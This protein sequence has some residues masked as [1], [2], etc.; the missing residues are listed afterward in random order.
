MR[1]SSSVTIVELRQYTLV[2][3]R[4]D[5]LIDLFDREFITPQEDV[6]A[7]II[8]QFRD[9]E[10]PERFVWLR[11]FKDMRSRAAALSAF[12]G[13][14]VWKAHRDAANATMVD[15]DNVLLLRPARPNSGFALAERGAKTDSPRV[16]PRTYVVT[17]AYFREPV[18][19]AFVTFFERRIVP[20]ITRAGGDVAAYFVT[21]YSPNDYPALPVRE[22]EHAFVWFSRFATTQAYAA[23]RQ[24]FQGWPGYAELREHFSRRLAAPVETHEL[25]ATSG[26][27]LQ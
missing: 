2:P 23:Y 19:E 6:G 22:G 14:P 12:Y 26:S 8:G 3:G 1:E 21:E 27:R 18:D 16:P 10:D 11:G 5:T 15:S 13:G 25:E 9:C 4:R 20:E 24:A 17:I 7:T